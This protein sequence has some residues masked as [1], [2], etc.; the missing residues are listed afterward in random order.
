MRCLGMLAGRPI[1]EAFRAG[2]IRQ[3]PNPH[4]PVD[5][6]V[7]NALHETFTSK[8]ALALRICGESWI[9]LSSLEASKA[10]RCFRRSVQRHLHDPRP[11]APDALLRNGM[12]PLDHVP[13]SQQ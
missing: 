5:K 9:E 11:G 2:V 8:L 4:D 3:Q 12:W 10:P 13:Q 6:H 1:K 7:S